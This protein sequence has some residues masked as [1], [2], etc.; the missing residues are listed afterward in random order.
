MTRFTILPALLLACIT[1]AAAE[2]LVLKADAWIDVDAGRRVTPGVVVVDGGRIAALNPASLPQGARTIELPGL[3]LLPGFIDAHTHLGSDL[4]EGWESRGVEWTDIDYALLGVRYARTTLESGFTTVRDVGSS[5]FYDV[6][7]MRAIERGDFPGPRIVPAGYGI[8]ATAGHCD[9]TGYAPGILEGGPEQGVADGPDEI[10]KAVRYQVKHGAK[11]I[12][13]CATAGVMSYEGPV[14]AQQYSMEELRA[15]VAEARLHGIPVAA[16][17]HGSEGIIAASEAGVDSIE[18]GSLLTGEAIR[19]LKKNGTWLVPTLYQWFEEYDL[20]PQLHEKNEFIK[21]RVGDS[22][23]RAF[24]AGVKVALGTDAGAGPHAQSG[25][26]FTSY[27]Q[28]GMSVAEA[29][30]SGTVN[31]AALL[32]VDDRGRL[33]PGLL[34]DIVAVAGDPL[35]D[36]RVVESVRF[37]MKGGEII[38]GP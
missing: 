30:R 34:A 7:L 12:K 23:R 28:H 38:R 11:V 37:V 32:R 24:A 9:W 16:H 19:V 20:P 18:H 6:A 25:R 36:I 26:E 21:A 3:T 27:V 10:V 35:T 5:G 17:A 8:G 14:A 4:G 22:M 29:L 2:V 15:A 13:V 33:E 31:A 1:P